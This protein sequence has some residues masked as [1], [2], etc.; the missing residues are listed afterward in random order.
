MRL[1]LLELAIDLITEGTT[2]PRPYGVTIIAGWTGYAAPALSV[3]ILTFLLMGIAY[4][5]VVPG[6]PRS[7]AKAAAAVIVTM[8]QLARPAVRALGLATYDAPGPGPSPVVAAA[9]TEALDHTLAVSR[10]RL[11]TAP[12][13]KIASHTTRF[14]I[15]TH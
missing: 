15:Q 7:Y 13:T 5:L 2:R 11:Q 8:L 4:C 10:R 3:A 6:R 12:A 9:W 14:R 1:L